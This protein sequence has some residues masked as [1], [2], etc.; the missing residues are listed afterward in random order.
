[1]PLFIFA[2]IFDGMISSGIGM[3]R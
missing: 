3:L 2:V 1:M